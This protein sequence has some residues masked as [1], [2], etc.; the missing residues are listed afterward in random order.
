MHT[1]DTVFVL[2]HKNVVFIKEIRIFTDLSQEESMKENL[3][4][5]LLVNNFGHL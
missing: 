4:S 3:G 5:C 1:N 2:S